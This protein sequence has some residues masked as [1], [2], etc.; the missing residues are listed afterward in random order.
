MGIEMMKLKNVFYFKELKFGIITVA[1]GLIPVTLVILIFQLL[2]NIPSYERQL[3]FQISDNYDIKMLIYY[4][5]SGC[6][7]FII[8]GII[9]YH[10]IQSL[11]KDISL[12]KFNLIRNT[13]ITV[14]LVMIFLV[15]FLDAFHIKLAFLSH[16]RLYILMEKSEFFK[17]SFRTFPIDFLNGIDFKWFRIFSVFPFLLVCF[18]LSVMV[19]GGFY[20]S[21][22]LRKYL[23]VENQPQ[24]SIKEYILEINT[25]LKNYARLLSIV[26]VSSTVATV[27]FFEVPVSLVKDKLIMNNYQ[28]VSLSMGVCWGLI[29][30]LTLLFLCIYPYNLAYKQITAVIQKVR[31]KEDKELEEWIDKNKSYYSLVGNL[32]LI[33]SIISPVA[34]SI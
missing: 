9:S 6:A 15:Y 19:F 22:E 1:L 29:F 14:L 20:I 25:T 8:C 28:S 32:N 21:K 26:L 13:L 30:S 27:L 24:D 23:E 34:V 5:I 3:Y 31:V 4:I 10:F 11:K 2:I 17:N 33:L 18:A 7:H 12:P 16:E